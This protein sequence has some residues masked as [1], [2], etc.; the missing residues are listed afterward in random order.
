M[1][2]IMNMLFLWMFG[3][4]VERAISTKQFTLLYF[5]S[6]IGSGLLTCFFPPFWNANV[7]GASGALFGVMVAFGLI[8]PDRVI[9]LFFIIPIRAFYMVI[10]MI[11]FETL[12][13]V[14]STGAGGTAH[15]THVSG[16]L[17]GWLFIK[18]AKRLPSP[19]Q[20]VIEIK[21]QREEI[22]EAAEQKRVDEILDKIN[23]DGM[24]TLSRAEREFLRRRAARRK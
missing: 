1:H 8:F 3:V 6:G 12:Y 16:A 2:L 15:I 5:I 14:S 13:L 23:R 17:F 20:K 4:D 21:K 19:K 7:I 18:Y 24:H 22:N 10:F 9:L 11:A